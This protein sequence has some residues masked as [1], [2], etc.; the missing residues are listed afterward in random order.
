MCE[1]CVATVFSQVQKI[2][3]FN[4]TSENGILVLHLHLKVLTFLFHDHGKHS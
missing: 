2:V 1:V 4:S 3:G